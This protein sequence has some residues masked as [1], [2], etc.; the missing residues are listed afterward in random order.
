MDLNVHVWLHDG[1]GLA[2]R[3]AH[4][5]RVLVILINR[6]VQIMATLAEVTAKQDAQEAAVVALSAE[7]AEEVVIIGE[8]KAALDALIAAGP[9]AATEAD[10]QAL[11]D[12]LDGVTTALTGATAALDAAGNAADITP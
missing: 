11:A 7:V 2:K 5:D 3:L 12:R 4:I 10:L 1:D 9:G 6:G 8:I